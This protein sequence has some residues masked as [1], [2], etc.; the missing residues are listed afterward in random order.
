MRWPRYFILLL[1][2]GLLAVACRTTPEPPVVDVVK[3]P[4]PQ[5]EP[6]PIP[7]QIPEPEPEPEPELIVEPEVEP[8]VPEAAVPIEVSDEVYEQTFTEVELVI[9]DLNEIV[10]REDYAKWRTHLSERYI[11][12]M[13]SPE[14]L[15]EVSSSPILQ[16]NEIV[17]EDLEDF[18][19]YVVVPSR[20]RSKLD[21]LV[22][23]SD[24]V[25][26]ALTERNDVLYLLYQLRKVD[27]QWKIDIF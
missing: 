21:E 22:F 25:V 7:E 16:R 12:I 3:E 4:E 17:L 23:Y 24:N 27:G 2:P 5:A 10:R 1:A 6:E 18:F 9:M 8:A 15:E 19:K 11:E 13:S 26:E 14:M 20:A